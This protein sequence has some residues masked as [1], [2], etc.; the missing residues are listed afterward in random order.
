MLCDF[1]DILVVSIVR[2]I[3]FFIAT[4]GVYGNVDTSA[5][6]QAELVKQKL[7]SQAVSIT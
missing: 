4:V 6:R 2:L 1:A 7:Q 5:E 3:S